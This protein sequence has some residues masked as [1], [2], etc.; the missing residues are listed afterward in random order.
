MSDERIITLGMGCFWSP[1]ALYGSLPGVVR[2]RVGYAGGAAAHPT[3]RDMGDHSETV[4]VAF[5][6]DLISLDQLLEIFWNNHNPI[7]IN[8]YKGRQYQ[9]L[10]LYR[11]ERQAEAFNRVKEMKET[12]KGY[13]LETEIAPLQTFH[14]AEPRHQKYYLKRFP[15]AM[16]KLGSLYG[17]EAELAQSRLAARLN[18]V[19]KGYA[20]LAPVLEEIRE[21]PLDPRE[22]ADMIEHVRQIRW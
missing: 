5:D 12:A 14:P 6:A 17:S 10:L 19:A 15:D 9:S 4:E 2:T 21:W 1:E 18:G 11:D 20:N 22:R 13:P 16:E 3:Y 7:N 8:G